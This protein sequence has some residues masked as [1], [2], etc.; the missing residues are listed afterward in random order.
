MNSRMFLITLLFFSYGLPS[1]GQ[2]N[3][4]TE[5]VFEVLAE[6]GWEMIENEPVADDTEMSD[7]EAN[8]SDALASDIDSE[9]V[10]MELSLIHI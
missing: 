2:E 5:D 6:N 1:W 10:D 3:T 4:E 9:F 8:D 7:A